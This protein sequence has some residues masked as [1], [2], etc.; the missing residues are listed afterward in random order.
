[1]VETIDG[2]L[3]SFSIE[4]ISYNYLPIKNSNFLW[5]ELMKFSHS[6]PL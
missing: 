3:P 1:M 2:A 6:D 4:I 5:Q